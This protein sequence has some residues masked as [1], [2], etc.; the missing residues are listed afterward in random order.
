MK[1]YNQVNKYN[2]RVRA[3]YTG[4]YEVQAN[5]LNEAEKKAQ[6]MLFNEMNDAVDASIDFEEYDPN[7]FTKSIFE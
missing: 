6:E 4:Y 7:Y 3:E 5:S 2:I 1:T